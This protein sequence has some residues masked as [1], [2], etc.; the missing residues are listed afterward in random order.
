MLNRLI[1]SINRRNYDICFNRFNI[2]VLEGTSGSGRT[3]FFND[4]REFIQIKKIKNICL[5]TY[6]D[7]EDNPL[8]ILQKDIDKYDLVVIDRADLVLDVDFELFICKYTDVN[9][10]IIGR[11]NFGCIPSLVTVGKL[12][13]ENN[14]IK[15][16]YGVI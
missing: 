1:F 16:N 15:V 14:V 4:L 13:N 6:K 12:R 8:A 11:K 10:I 2:M 7:E 3:L 9:W 5:I